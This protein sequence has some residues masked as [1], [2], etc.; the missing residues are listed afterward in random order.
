MLIFLPRPVIINLSETRT[1]ADIIAV[2]FSVQEVCAA[3]GDVI[4]KATSLPKKILRE[5]SL[6]HSPFFSFKTKKKEKRLMRGRPD[7]D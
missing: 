7:C 4:L 3:V 5:V 6:L 1:S 2:Q